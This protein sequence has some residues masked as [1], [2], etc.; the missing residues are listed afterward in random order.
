MNRTAAAV[1]LVAVLA[2]VLAL[3]GW[4][5]EGHRVIGDIAQER[6]TEVTKRN[7]QSLI[8]NNTL[9]SVSNWADEIRPQRDETYGMEGLMNVADSASMRSPRG[10]FLSPQN[11][12]EIFDPVHDAVLVI[13][14]CPFVPVLWAVAVPR[15]GEA[16]RVLGNI[17]EVP[18]TSGRRK[19]ATAF[20]SRSLAPAD[21]VATSAI[22]TL[23]ETA[24]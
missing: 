23:L 7:V 1:V 21:V 9:A 16:L 3:Y 8:G 11:P 14:L 24:D 22:C 18:V 6:L 10:A 15:M 17:H 2:P 12:L 20:T 19:A 13:I 5:R 4:G